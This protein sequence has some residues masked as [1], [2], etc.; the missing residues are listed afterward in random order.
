MEKPTTT[1]WAVRLG[2]GWSSYYFG[3][4]KAYPK[5]YAAALNAKKAPPLR[6]ATET[7]AEIA[8]AAYLDM[9]A[10][11][12]PASVVQVKASPTHRLTNEGFAP[13]PLAEAFAL[14]APN[15]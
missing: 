14:F 11:P 5:G 1:A 12:Y 2:I 8:H 9:T 4:S 3:W 15:L 13:V 6:F 10:D 7:E